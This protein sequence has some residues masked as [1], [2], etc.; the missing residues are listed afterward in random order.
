[1]QA[2][3][4]RHAD[5]DP[6]DSELYPYIEERGRLHKLAALLHS[7]PAMPPTAILDSGNGIQPLWAIARQPLTP[8]IIETTE[9]ENRAIEAAVGAAGTHN[10]DRL[11]RLPGTLN[12]PNA[13][14]QRLGR[15]VT[16]ARLLYF[17]DARYTT[18]QASGLGAHLQGLLVGTG[19][20]RFPAE[21]EAEPKKKRNIKRNLI[22]RSALAMG[23]V[24]GLP[25]TGNVLRRNGAGTPRRSRN[26][27][28]VQGKRRSQRR[29]RT[30]VA[31]GTRPVKPQTKSTASSPSSM[32]STWSS[33][34]TERD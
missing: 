13:A 27:R 15:R 29:A 7:N 6:H 25:S 21:T 32:P 16:R 9:A 30:A 14:K 23:K 18:E 28:V 22:D 17:T 20:V 3:L 10:I 5:I 34:K 2:A 19:L 33:T 1:M 12:Y 31:S 11:L 8:E 26:S 24:C 4:C